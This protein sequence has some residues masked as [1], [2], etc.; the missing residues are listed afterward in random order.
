M[1]N[2]YIFIAQ[3]IIV[4]HGYGHQ[5]T[6]LASCSHVLVAGEKFLSRK[7]TKLCKIVLTFYFYLATKAA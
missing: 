2:I 3:H 1:T 7:F 6:L 5:L 4:L